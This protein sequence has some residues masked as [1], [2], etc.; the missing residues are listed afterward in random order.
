MQLGI[1]VGTSAV[2]VVL[3]D[4][5]Q[6]IRSADAPLTVQSPQSGWSEQNPED[7][8]AAVISAIGQLGDVA[9]VQSVG[10]S[11][12]MHGAVLLG[13]DQTVLRPAILWNDNRSV[14]ECRTL[15]DRCP[16][17]GQRAG[18]PPLPGFTAPKLMWLKT[19]NRATYAN[20]R[21]ILLPKDYIG[22]CL[23]GG[24]ATD[25]SDAAGTLWFDQKNRSWSSTLCNAS[26]TDPE[27]L[28]ELY[29][30]NQPC[31]ELSRR[32]AAQTGLPAGIPVF[33]GG[34]DAATGAM[35][36]GMTEP[37]RG[38]IS[39]GTSGQILVAGRCYRPNPEAFVHAFA[40]TVPD[41]WYQMAALLNGARPL[42]WLSGILDLPVGDVL[43]E[44]QGADR[45]RAPIFLPYLTGERSPLGD[46][47]VRGSFALLGDS[48]TRKELA[49][50]VVEA[51]AFSFDNAMRSF[52]E[53]LTDVTHFV[54]VGGGS[55][56]DYLLQMIANVTGQEIRRSD[57]APA[58]AA[59]G[60]AFLAQ[61]DLEAASDQQNCGATVFRPASDDLAMER[62]VEF[63]ELYRC[64]GQGRMTSGSSIAPS[65]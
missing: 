17:I 37:D 60:A 31:G 20:L 34:G 9:D 13:G 28:P 4:G 50:S 41:R 32:A 23:H 30:G 48:T 25:M 45:S 63:E 16:D 52:G 54:A 24:L 18:V 61:P 35:S 6:L 8:W 39:L 33:A 40:H 47:H 36:L 57:T 21:H 12:Q 51:I 38:M 19:H 59:L 62:K 55:R 53:T 46:P 15:A 11:G 5:H 43:R 1:D 26:E 10:L 27:W 65:I 49:Y 42:S 2:K 14:Q 3:C 22:F 44:A 64:I 29:F 58:G 56:S 7:W